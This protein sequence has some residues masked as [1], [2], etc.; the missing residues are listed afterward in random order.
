MRYETKK[1]LPPTITNVLPVDAQGVYLETYN[2]A[3]D[4]FDQETTGDLSRH[5]I[6]HRQAWETIERVFAR[7]VNTGAWEHKGGEVAEYD[8][9]SFL[10]KVRDAIAGVLS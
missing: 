2:R 6:A 10:D 9:R 4:E 3:W 5:S 1:N 8:A 7:D